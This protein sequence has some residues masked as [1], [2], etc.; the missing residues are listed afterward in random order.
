MTAVMLRAPAS[1]TASCHRRSST[2]L[3]SGAVDW[4]TTASLPR[5]GSSRRAYPSPSGKRLNSVRTE[6]APRS[7]ASRAA[8]GPEA[9]PA[10]TAGGIA[11][12]TERG[13]ISGPGSSGRPGPGLAHDGDQVVRLVGREGHGVDGS[14]GQA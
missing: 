11:Q 12:P 3:L 13:H 9:V 5:T 7:F 14:D 8:K 6:D 10:T 4:Q 2:R 1:R